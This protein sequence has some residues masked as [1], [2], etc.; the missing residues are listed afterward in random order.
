[1]IAASDFLFE[2]PDFLRKKFYRAAALG[3]DHVVMAAAV[4]LVLEARNPIVKGDFAGQSAFGEQF[5]RAIDSGI[6]DA[7]VFFLH[8][9]VQF[10]S[11]KMVAGFE[12]GPQ[13]G[14]SLAGLL[15]AHAF[16]M[17]VQNALGFA[18]HLAGDGGLIIDAFLQHGR[19]KSKLE[20][21]VG[22][23]FREVENEIHFQRRLRME[24][25]N[26]IKDSHEHSDR[27]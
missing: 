24:R 23:A 6:A 22:I 10:I 19:G 12:E 26:T 15:E 9:A 1:V 2:Y 20:A 17:A 16:E 21:E 3:A 5:Q 14:I 13:D 7:G 8:E 27:N 25:W 11:G 4:V 18:N